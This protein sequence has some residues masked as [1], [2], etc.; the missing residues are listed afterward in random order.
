MDEINWEY[1]PLTMDFADLINCD[2]FHT[3]SDNGLQGDL[4]R[5]HILLACGWYY[6]GEGDND[7][8]H[9]CSPD[10]KRDPVTF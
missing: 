5:W 4:Y 1:P 2:Q 6:T 9:R 3:F 10:Q 7:T 8:G